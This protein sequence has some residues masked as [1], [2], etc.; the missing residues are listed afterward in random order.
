MNME[1]MSNFAIEKGCTSFGLSKNNKFLYYVI[2]N[3]RRIT[4]GS[5]N[6][7][8]SSEKKFIQWKNKNLLYF[9]NGS[10]VDTRDKL[11]WEWQTWTKFFGWPDNYT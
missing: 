8:Y 4:F 2:Y 5:S 11:F 9:V 6:C 3:G 7:D 1:E 10:M